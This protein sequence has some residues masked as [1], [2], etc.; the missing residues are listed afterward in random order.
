MV[1]FRDISI[2]SKLMAIIMATSCIVLLLG[3]ITLTVRY[4]ATEQ[5]EMTQRMTVLAEV[6]GTNTTAALAFNDAT[7][8]RDTLTALVAEP[9]LI[10]ARI[11]R[12][13]GALFAR[14][15]TP[16]RTFSPAEMRPGNETRGSVLF[17]GDRLTISSPIM[18]DG[19]DI[20]TVRLDADLQP[21]R[22]RLLNNITMLALII[23]AAGLLALP[24][25]SRLQKIVSNPITHLAQTMRL[26]SRARDYSV[27]A[28]KQGDDEVG[29]LID[30]FN[31][32]LEQISA[33][34]EQ[35]RIAANALEN[36]GDAIMITDERLK[37]VSVNKA[38]STMTGFLPEEVLDS[39]PAMLRS[40]RHSAAF[41]KQLWRRVCCYGQ[42]HGEIWGRRNNGEVF[43]QWLTISEIRDQADKITH[44][45]FVSNDISQQ[46]IYEANL[47]HQAHHDALTELP[48]RILF[49]V[50]LQEALRRAKRHGERLGLMFIDLDNFKSIND[51]L[52]HAAGDE[53]LQT[54]AERLKICLRESDVVARRG[55]DE[56]TVLLDRLRQVE[57][58]A[59][60]AEKFI[61]ELSRPVKLAGQIR[62]VTASIGICCYPED[63]LEAPELMKNADMAMYLAKQQGRNRFQFY[64]TEPH[65]AP[66]VTPPRL[67]MPKV[68]SG[69]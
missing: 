16:G 24:I 68:S 27:R 10:E 55:G 38:F 59:V 52:G 61:A 42:W 48:N 29:T 1:A 51:T 7:S 22:L 46:K 50:H 40:D 5:E 31:E 56:F 54:V 9:S 18:L 39:R 6:I 41:Y 34:D 45:V 20:G 8:A 37:I 65:P 25:S 21:L 2:R 32:M 49:E 58:A 11:Y 53:L 64:P 14:F 4:A 36:T 63:G 17:G 15:T 66:P 28:E 44:Y 3:G 60:I 62:A 13:N 23:L 26:V 57:D 19:E 67:P 12:R 35:L 30:G 69:R 47:E 33:R 43:P